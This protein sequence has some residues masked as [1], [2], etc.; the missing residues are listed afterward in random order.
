MRLDSAI[1]S[2]WLLG[3]VVSAAMW[4]QGGVALAQ[5]EK[6]EAACPVMG[7]KYRHT[8]AGGM[9]NRDWWPNR[10][11]LD[12]LHQ[13]SALV[14]PMGADFD[15][16]AEFAK[17]DLDAL[18]KDIDRGDD[19]PRRTWW[20]ADW[21]HYGPSSSAWPGTAPA[22]TASRTAAAAPRRARSA[23]LRSGAGRTTPTSTR[24]AAAV[25][26]QEEVRQSSLLGRPDHLLGA[27]SRWSRWASRRFGFAGGRAD[28]WE[29]EKDV[30]WGPETTWLGDKRFDDDREFQ[31]PLAA[32]QMGLIYVNPEG[33]N[34]KP[35]PIAAA[36]DIRV[37]FGAW[38]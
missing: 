23:S 5:E 34:G 17:L 10:L 22:P 26:G 3:L 12:I 33:P 6:A 9:G 11:N 1:R 31:N 13:N 32:S 14:S 27:T 19:R 30:N 7:P 18:R 16:A 21:G 38:R 24:R 20:P 37:T 4:A 25:A 2:T 35:D 15:Y 8:A 36:H 29:P 28:V